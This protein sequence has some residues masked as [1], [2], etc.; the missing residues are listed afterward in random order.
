MKDEITNK[1]R[2]NVCDMRGRLALSFVIGSRQAPGDVDEV[3]SST[4]SIIKGAC[5]SLSKNTFCYTLG[6]EQLAFSHAYIFSC[7][8]IIVYVLYA[9]TH[10]TLRNVTY[11]KLKI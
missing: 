2:A 11:R 5:L 1:N 9:V 4:F 6:A 3:Y 8:V 7:Y 10:V